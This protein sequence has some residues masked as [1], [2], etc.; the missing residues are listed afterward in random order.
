MATKRLPPSIVAAS[1]LRSNA[2]LA[3]L[4]FDPDRHRRRKERMAK[5]HEKQRII[6]D[7]GM[8]KLVADS[9]VLVPSPSLTILAAKLGVNRATLRRYM[10]EENLKK[11]S[12]LYKG[13][14]EGKSDR[15][16]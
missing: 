14:K 7:P 4:P 8:I 9:I 16:R 3:S 15:N 11:R 2:A 1:R 13:P 10:R 12:S 6:F 5:L